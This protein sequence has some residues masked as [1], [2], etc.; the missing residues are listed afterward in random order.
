[1]IYELEEHLI[2]FERWEDILDNFPADIQAE[3]QY[4]IRWNRGEEKFI[5]HS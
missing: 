2:P 1:M 4:I 3:A 5:P